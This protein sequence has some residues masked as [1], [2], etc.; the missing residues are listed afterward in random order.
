MSRP[1]RIHVPEGTYY[2]VHRGSKYGSLF[3]QPDDYVLFE[4]LLPA[5]LERS[6]ALLHAYC[7]TS[8]AIHLAVQAMNGSVSRFIQGL[9]SAYARQM[10]E[11]LGARGHFFEDRHSQTLIGTHDYLLRLINY[12]HYIPILENAAAAVDVYPHTSHQAYLGARNVPW[13][14]TQTARRLIGDSDDGRSG[15]QHLMSE[16]PTPQTVDLLKRGDPRTPGIVGD[17]TFVDSLPRQ[18]RPYR[19]RISL[20]EIASN[21]VCLRGLRR[22]IIFSKSRVREYALARAMITWYATERGVAGLNE[23]ARYLCRDP[24]TLSSAV[25]RYRTIRP[26]L[27]TLGMFRSLIPLGGEL[28]AARSKTF[29]RSDDMTVVSA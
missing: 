25:N 7:W 4:S 1:R 24:S 2:I 20:D 29:G 13:L 27:F 15:Y 14:H 19:C 10:N 21:V 6:G 9:A 18:V 17:D 23:V 26:D 11:H 16:A 8:D 12:I 5:V 22:E 28:S 3:L